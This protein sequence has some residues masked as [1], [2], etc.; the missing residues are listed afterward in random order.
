MTTWT[1]NNIRIFVQE[2]TAD[3]TQIIPRLQPLDGPTI[4]QFFGYESY[5]RN[6]NAYVVGSTDMAALLNLR[7]STTAYNLMSPMGDLGDYYVKKVSFKQI[8]NVC[9]TLRPDLAEDSPMYITDIELYPES[10]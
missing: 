10:D 9:Q 7:K 1:L 6:I 3:A 4:L 2:N 5:V 8:R